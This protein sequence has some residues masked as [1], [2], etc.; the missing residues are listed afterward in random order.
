MVWCYLTTSDSPD[1][2]R[3]RLC[4]VHRPSSRHSGWHSSSLETLP[5]H[6]EGYTRGR[7]GQL[8]P[9]LIQSW[10][11][12]GV[13]WCRFT[14]TVREPPKLKTQLAS[15][16]CPTCLR[17]RP[18]NHPNCSTAPE[19]AT[20]TRTHAQKKKPI[21]Q[22]PLQN[23]KFKNAD[24]PRISISNRPEP[25][26]KTTGAGFQATPLQCHGRNALQLSG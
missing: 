5:I 4:T 21:R 12:K 25:C 8:V 11:K 22:R 20:H 14:R 13:R 23:S 9:H 18:R 17:A 6:R 3:R 15:E 2:Y 1:A 7:G 16:R 10:K 19:P 24:P 26:P